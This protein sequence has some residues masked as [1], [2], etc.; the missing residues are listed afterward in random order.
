MDSEDLD[1]VCALRCPGCRRLAVGITE[2]S[3][4]RTVDAYNASLANLHPAE[5]VARVRQ[6]TPT[7]FP[8]KYCSKCQTPAVY[9]EPAAI[10]TKRT[11]SRAQRVVAPQLP[12]RRFS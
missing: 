4:Q 3:A 2:A 7:M 9:F 10:K 12:F 6:R 11:W 5:W 1:I 8:Y